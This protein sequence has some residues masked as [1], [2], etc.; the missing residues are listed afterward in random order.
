M[1][2][3]KRDILQF[4]L[5]VAILVM[6]NIIGY[7]RFL[8]IDL[9]ADQRFTLSEATKE[10]LREVQDPIIVEVYLEGN[11]PAGFQRLQRETRQMLDEFRAYQPKLQ[12]R[13]IN[14]NKAESAEERE[15][16][17]QQLQQKGIRP[18]QL[19]A[20]DKEGASSRTIYPG[21]LMRLGDQEVAIPLL[22]SQLATDV[23]RQ[24][25][26]SLQNLE[27]ALANGLKQMLTTQRPLVAFI[28]GHGEL[29]RLQVYD[30][31]RN[32]SPFYNLSV[33]DLRTFVQDSLSG[34][35]S[36]SAQQR[37]LNRF[38]ALIIAKPQRGFNDIDK[39]LID[40][41]IMNGG[42][43]VWLLDAVQASMDS[44]SKRPQF[45]S[46]PL[47]D[48]L[49]LGD[50]LFRYGVRIN[51]NLV[52]DLIAARVSD[53][54]E[55]NPWIYFP[56]VMPQIPH[57]ITKNLN[58][59]R[60]QFPSSVDTVRA[61]GIRKTFLLRSSP[62]ARKV[63]TPHLVTLGALYEQPD[64]ARYQQSFIPMGVLLEGKFSSVFANRITPKDNGEPLRMVEQCRSEN[65]MVV[66]A[67]GDLIR[68]QLNVVNPNL[69]KGA[70]LPLGYDQYTGVTYGNKNLMLNIMDY[71]LDDSGLISVRSKNVKMRLLDRQNLQQ[72]RI[73]WQVLNTALPV[74]LLLL[75]GALWQWR[76]RKAF[77][78]Y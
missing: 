59:I 35:V 38:D 52:T 21:A 33:F 13:F 5:L 55:S 39:Y 69:E 66:I 9:T 4:V 30:L 2:R 32:M 47:Y 63:A 19:Q 22:V 62:Y 77:G 72:G 76:R 36:L 64:P 67:D 42:K 45:L 37:S 1:E 23:A 51:T 34:K 58:A 46:L 61:P 54:R 43:V 65:Q 29:E 75:A 57:P 49:Q 14:P 25:N 27:Y 24:L 20:R 73:F 56:Q 17:Q 28:Q 68:N 41:Y 12:Y 18:F 3:K 70:P 74:V 71:L 53:G 7:Y 78:S 15:Q 31:A 26:A 6:V 40:Q 11:F 44:L 60:L 8:R 16:L 48:R 10:L 50:M